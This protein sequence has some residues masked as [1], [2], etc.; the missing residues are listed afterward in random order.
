MV[1]A[2]AVT[3]HSAGPGLGHAHRNVVLT[4]HGAAAG[5][6]RY[7]YPTVASRCDGVVRAWNVG[8]RMH[9]RRR[10]LSAVG[11]QSSEAPRTRI[12]A[13]RARRPG[14]CSGAGLQDERRHHW[15]P[16]NPEMTTGNCARQWECALNGVPMAT[17]EMRLDRA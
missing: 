6:C 16:I 14:A 15:S 8:S 7:C 10:C 5:G 3:T 4:C 13:R 11:V 1:G 17:G 12:R 9:R 2:G